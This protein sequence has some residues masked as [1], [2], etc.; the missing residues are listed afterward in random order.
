MDTVKIGRFLAELRHEHHETQ[1]QLG[2]ILGV[3]NK[4]ISRW[5]NGNYLPP[6]EMLLLISEHY[7][8]DMN[9]ILAGERLSEMKYKEKAEE[10]I[11]T[12]LK[13]SS[14]SVKEKVSFFKKKWFKER[15]AFFVMDIV[16]F[17]G[18]VC[19]SLIKQNDYWI[20]ALIGMFV[21]Y[22]V[23]YNRMMMYVEK[24]AYDGSGG[25]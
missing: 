5:E 2:E 16:V 15:I 12:V 23:M 8:V 22:I 7:L 24:R 25:R 19:W 11:K 10:N 3:S 6:I 17:L 21:W 14:F 20:V 1:E 13:E 9:E 4:T 18:I